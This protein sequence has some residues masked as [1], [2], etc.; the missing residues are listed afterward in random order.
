MAKSGLNGTL[1]VMSTMSR[2]T[3]LFLAAAL[4]MLVACVFLIN[5]YKQGIPMSFAMNLVAAALIALLVPTLT[6][7]AYAYFL[8]E[9]S[10]RF[11]VF[12]LTCLCLAIM[13]GLMTF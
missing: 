8:R 1:T 7:A 4:S 9:R 5:Q 3:H 2:F 11:V 13:L 6:T 12:E 10:G